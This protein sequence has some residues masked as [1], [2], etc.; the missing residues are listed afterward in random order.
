MSALLSVR[1]LF[2]NP[3]VRNF[4]LSP[5]G[6][7]L[8]F[9]KNVKSRMTLH[10][11][12]ADG[13][14][15]RMLIPPG[16]RDIPG[17]FWGNDDI[18]LFMN[19]G[20][21]DENYHIYS[22]PSEGGEVRD[23]TP[24]AGAQALPG[25][26]L[27]NDKEQIFVSCNKRNPQVMDLYTLNYITGEMQLRYENNSNFSGFETDFNDTVRLAL[28]HDG[29]STI[30]FH[31]A[32][33]SEEF[34]LLYKPAD[35]EKFNPI[36]FINDNRHLLVGA[37]NGRDKAGIYTFDTQTAQFAE[38]MYYDEEY[39]VALDINFFGGIN[40]SKKRRV[41]VVGFYQRDYPQTFFFDDYFRKV[42]QEVLDTLGEPHANIEH[43]G[44]NDEETIFTFAVSSDTHPSDEYLYNAETKQLK[45]LVNQSPWIPRN[46]M[47]RKQPVRYQS[48]DGRTIH[49]YLT[50]P[51]G[52]EPKNLPAVIH[53]HGGPNHVRDVWAWDA[54][55]QFL[56]TRGYAVLQPNYR[57][58]DG[59]G[60]EFF[61]I[62]FKQWGRTMQDDLSD[63]VTW[64]IEQGIADSR[65][66]AIMGGSYGGYATLAGVTFTPELYCCGV[67]I[68]GPSNMFTFL[69]SIPPY[70]EPLRE[71]MYERIG[72]PERD[73]ELLHNASPLFFAENIRVPMFIAQGAND[74]RV[75]QVESEQI[76]DMLRSQGKEVEY[77]LK[78]N[79][80]HGFH[81]EENRF[82]L[83]EA[84]EKF[85]AK[86]LGGQAAE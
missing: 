61:E 77:M 44:Y 64:L 76:V 29:V 39:D 21:G 20:G 37:N 84:I 35:Y 79:E 8:A 45:L 15:E 50:L 38:E 80:G 24:F 27:H 67:S 10:I 16:E 4:L 5:N 36:A 9:L 58:S 73:R 66:V 12:N 54:T 47:P 3:D 53:P 52:V 17:F 43:T 68:V 18:I 11:C 42:Y 63:G 1:Q 33:D 56:A 71:A 59:Y 2:R 32:S 85:L 34:Q 30:V 49:A 28:A 13:T 46:E 19:D 83:Y 82:E 22:V 81:I 60:K 78:E 57:G 6:K 51:T 75:K 72:H 31:R 41:P 70:W 14:D 23:L 74:P 40:F 55:A 7:R 86:N 65:R 26:R 69:D 48:R 62:C 25:G